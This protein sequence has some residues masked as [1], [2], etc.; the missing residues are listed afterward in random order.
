MKLYIQFDNHLLTMTLDGSLPN[1][2][3]KNNRLFWCVE[4]ICGIVQF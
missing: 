2:G 4:S 3:T 1:K